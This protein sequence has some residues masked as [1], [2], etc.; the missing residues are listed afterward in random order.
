MPMKLI[1][2]TLH[3][4]SEFLSSSQNM[5]LVRISYLQE[6][7]HITFALPWLH[8]GLI[9][10]TGFVFSYLEIQDYTEYIVYIKVYNVHKSI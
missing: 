10:I 8:H 7:T 1:Y 5:K 4:L 6:D 2:K 3:N 9:L